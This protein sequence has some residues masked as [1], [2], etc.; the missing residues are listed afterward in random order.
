MPIDLRK[1]ISQ[2]LELRKVSPAFREY[3]NDLVARDL[4]GQTAPVNPSPT[5]QR[6]ETPPQ[7]TIPIKEEKKSNIQTVKK[8]Q[9]KTMP[10]TEEETA[11]VD[12]MLAGLGL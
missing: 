12:D 2:E 1:A 6:T 10:P 4:Q 11:K 3:L 5:L 7:N 8:S 9:P